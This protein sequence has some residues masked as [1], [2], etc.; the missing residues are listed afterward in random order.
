MRPGGGG[1]PQGRSL[2]GIQCAQTPNVT[3]RICRSLVLRFVALRSRRSSGQM[4]SVLIAAQ[5]AQINFWF[6]I[7][8]G[9]CRKR[10][11]LTASS[12]ILLAVLHCSEWH[13][14]CTVRQWHCSVGTLHSAA[15]Q[16][17]PLCKQRQHSYAP[18]CAAKVVSLAAASTGRLC[19]LTIEQW[20]CGDDRKP[21]N[22]RF[23]ELAVCKGTS[24]LQVNRA[25]AIAP[26]PA[27]QH[28]AHSIYK[29]TAT[30][31]KRKRHR[32]ERCTQTATTPLTTSRA[33]PCRRNQ[34]HQRQ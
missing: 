2:R 14:A 18:R 9:L 23:S 26:H 21:Q 25:R 6:S 5:A 19:R 8:R 31:S 27:G 15:M 11:T 29:T 13:D 30:P 3:P 12:S 17:V 33:K 16:R 32:C 28:T 4:H 7:S 20:R 10:S 22:S 34:N 1:K 24:K